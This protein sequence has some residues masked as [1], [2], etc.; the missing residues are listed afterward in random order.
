MAIVPD[1]LRSWRKPRAVIRERLAGPEREDRALVTLMGAS[2][3]L[4]VAQWPSLS[5]AAFL[6]PSV[7]LDARMGGALMGCLFLVP[8]FAY[9]LAALSHWIAKAL[10][11]Q[12]SGYGARVALFW[13]LLAVSPAVLFQG[14]IAGFIGPGAGLAAVGVIVAVAFFWIWLSMLAEAERRI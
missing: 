8:L 12:G 13:A 4:F 10:G 14:L 3:L 1:I 5:R 11:G 6:D 7:P 9:A 2:L